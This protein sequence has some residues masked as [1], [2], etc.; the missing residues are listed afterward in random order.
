VTTDFA[1]M[2]IQEIQHLISTRQ[3]SAVEVI[4][5][6]LD[7]QDWLEPTLNA[8]VTRTP[9]MALEAAR[10]VDAQIMRGD[11]LGPLA[12]VPIS[13][14]DL[15]DVAGVPTTFGS[16]VMAQNV[17]KGDAPAVERV[18][19]AGACVLGKTTTTE[20]GC[21]AGGGD[22]PLTG[23]TRN[24]WDTA[25]STGGSSAGAAASV[26]AGVTPIAVGTDG[27]GSCRI[28]AAL[29]GL[30]GVKAQYGRVPVFPA[31]ATPSL[32]H[33][34]SIGRTVRD[35]AQLLQVLSGF[36][37][38]DPASVAQRVPDLIGACDRGAA[39]L[40]IAWS[41]TLGYAPVSDEVR[42][43]TISAVGRL[44][45]AGCTV[46]TVDRVFPED[47]I[48][49]WNAEFYAGVG[50]KLK[51]ALYDSRELLDPAVVE[52]IE[53]A[54][55][56]QSVEEYFLKYFQRFDLRE[57]FR[58]FLEPYDLLITPTLPVADLAAGVNVPPELTDRNIVSWVYYTYPFNLTGNPAA[59]VPCGFTAEGMP[60]GLQIVAKTLCEVNLFRVAGVL[61][62]V[63]PWS[64][65]H[66]V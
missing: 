40:R 20:F 63:S 1:Y 26:A 44:E 11:A 62:A 52:V 37:A 6:A 55:Y 12:G 60:V 16:R 54:L 3:A 35:A 56:S 8:F 57:H 32:A 28:P 34:G 17:A 45:E 9:E 42:Q 27:G 59:S 50:L 7:R 23:V 5:A 22:S 46:Q 49:L 47:P 66:P 13:I 38:R 48:E 30:V 53:D 58:K 25:K 51:S 15:I 36:D 61:E 2:S 14:K 10:K 18:K 43:L 39:N 65:R 4:G 29:C 24:P 19:H 21:K 33:V 31:G 64:H 41:P